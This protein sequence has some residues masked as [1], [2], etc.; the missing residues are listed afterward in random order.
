MADEL[1]RTGLDEDLRPFSALLWQQR[2]AHR[3]VEEGGEQVL[4][5]VDAGDR[6][7][8][9]ALLSRW[10]SGE[11]QIR[12]QPR[13]ATF[14]GAGFG[15]ALRAAPVSLALIALSVLGF[16]LVYLGP[17]SW[18]SALTYNPFT[19]QGGEP[20]FAPQGGEYWRLVTP[21]F[22]HFG[23]LHIVF[24]SLWC[25]ELG[26]RIE[27]EIGPGNLV[28]LFLVIAAVSNFAQHLV[29][30][31]VLFGGLSG[32]VYGWLGF[33]AVAGRLNPRWQ[34]MAP[35]PPI[36]LFMV[37]WLL[38]C[39]FGLVDVL[40]FSVANAAHVGGLLSGAGLG[41]LFALAHRGSS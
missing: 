20:A 39:L 22:L 16:L 5:L 12:L 37:G 23:W 26:R 1:Y 32:V 24:N 13:A 15:G 31:P 14:C 40:G 36:L 25:W 9:A 10:L 29:T 28:G 11:L 4:R 38:V 2:I 19:L 33:G 34:G 27:Q 41:A 18:V 30:G 21:V 35:A 17:V 8:A 6:P 7:R 3:I